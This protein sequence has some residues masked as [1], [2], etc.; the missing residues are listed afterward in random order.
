MGFPVYVSK[1]REPT[2]VVY[3]LCMYVM[4]HGTWQT[5][6]NRIAFPPDLR[7]GRYVFCLAE[8]TFINERPIRKT[9][10]R[11]ILP[12]GKSSLDDTD[13]SRW[14]FFF[15][16]RAQASTFSTLTRITD[17]SILRDARAGYSPDCIRT[18]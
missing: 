16:R 8:Q 18:L 17:A 7:T 3:N 4:M 15:G 13:N 11:R 5:G 1:F 6:K 10:F 9:G 12:F 2:Q 14:T